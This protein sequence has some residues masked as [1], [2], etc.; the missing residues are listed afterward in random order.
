MRIVIFAFFAAGCGVATAQD[1][2]GNSP[3]VTV[4]ASPAAAE[5]APRPAP[6]GLLVLPTLEF[7]LT[8][9]P[10]CGNAGAAESVTISVADT[11]RRIPVDGDVPVETTV[12]LPGRQ[13]SPIRAEG[14]CRAGEQEAARQVLQVDDAFSARLSLRCRSGESQTVVYATVPLSIRLICAAPR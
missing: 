4:E 10:N 2:A 11:R 9:L 13:A 1:P 7:A 6:P 5:I 12:L 8:I 3:R 14:F